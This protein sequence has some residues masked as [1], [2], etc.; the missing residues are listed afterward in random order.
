MPDCDACPLNYRF[1][2]TYVLNFDY[3]RMLSALNAVFVRN[4]HISPHGLT[5]LTVNVRCPEITNS[6][7]ASSFSKI[8]AERVS[9]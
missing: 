6:A 7:G 5:T 3:V 8:V 2:S 9:E 1:A 4:R